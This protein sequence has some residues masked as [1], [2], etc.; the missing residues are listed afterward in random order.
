MIASISL[1][2]NKKG[3]TFNPLKA[4]NKKGK[5]TQAPSDDSDEPT[6]KAKHR[7]KL[8]SLSREEPD[9]DD[10]E[11]EVEPMPFCP[12]PAKLKVKTW[13]EVIYWTLDDPSSSKLAQLTMVVVMVIIV[14]SCVCFCLESMPEFQRVDPVCK[15][16]TQI[17]DSEDCIFAEAA[18]NE[19]NMLSCYDCKPVSKEFFMHAETAC[20]IVFTVEYLLRFLTVH[21]LPARDEYNKLVAANLQP[22]SIRKAWLMWK[23]TMNLIDFFAIIPFYIELMFAGSG[24]GLA[25]LRVL[26]LARVFRIFKLGKYSTGMQMFASTINESVPALSMVGFLL[27]IAVVLCGSMVFFAEGGSWEFDNKYDR[28]VMTRPTTNGLDTEASPFISIPNSFWWVVITATTVGYGDYYPTTTAG[29]FVGSFVSLGGIILLALPITIIGQN[30]QHNY[31]TAQTQKKE[32]AHARKSVVQRRKRSGGSVS[33]VQEAMGGRVGSGLINRRPSLSRFM[34]RTGSGV[35]A[36]RTGSGVVASR[37]GSAVVASRTGSIGVEATG[38]GVEA[39]RS[40]SIGT[41]RKLREKKKEENQKE[42]SFD[43]DLTNEALGVVE[44]ALDLVGEASTADASNPENSSTPSPKD[45]DEGGLGDSDAA[46]FFEIEQRLFMQE[47]T[48]REVQG[49]V[50]DMQR[51]LEQ[52]CLQSGVMLRSPSGR[53]VRKNRR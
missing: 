50:L 37:T 7:I 4:R 6:H 42:V 45:S 14:F 47:T 23:D 40:G 20:I 49:T 51:L 28:Y 19:M 25:V 2:A 46:H 30:F 38:S 43:N 27:L 29:K 33:S 5:V 3:G 44:Q 22:G 48:L 11:S 34:S 36:S 41:V 18:G 10:E 1:S 52:L 21:A 24:G 31:M 8:S 39:A 12:N 15:N 26:R 17:H 9:S 13:R 16:S 32:K 53:D 35:V